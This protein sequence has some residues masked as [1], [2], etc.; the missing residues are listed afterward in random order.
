[1][2]KR[3]ELAAAKKAQ[4]NSQAGVEHDSSDSDRSSGEEETHQVGVCVWVCVCV[5]MCACAFTTPALSASRTVP[6]GHLAPAI[7]HI[8][9][10]V[11]SRHASLASQFNGRGSWPL[12]S[13][14]S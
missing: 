3:Q 5:R 4:E 6:Q 10:L 11:L 2:A 9:P 12:C 1:M 8:P 7:A 13:G 14:C